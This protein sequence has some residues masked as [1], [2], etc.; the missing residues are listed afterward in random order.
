[1]PGGVNRKRGPEEREDVLED[2]GRKTNRIGGVDDEVS[3][4]VERPGKTGLRVVR[5]SG[6]RGGSGGS[7]KEEIIGGPLLLSE[8]LGCAR[9]WWA[10]VAGGFCV[11]EGRK[12]GKKKSKGGKE[13]R[14]RRTP[15]VC[16]PSKRTNLGGGPGLQEGVR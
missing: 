6:A 4:V 7:R 9:A 14:R 13:R 3:T 8:G 5:G 10:K 12:V 1:M 16:K 11:R 2:R 15:H